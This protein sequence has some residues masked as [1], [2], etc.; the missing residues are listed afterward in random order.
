MAAVQASPLTYQN[1]AFVQAVCNAYDNPEEDINRGIEREDNTLVVRDDYPL[2]ILTA[3]Q[4]ANQAESQFA[5]PLKVAILRY[6][7]TYDWLHQTQH[8]RQIPLSGEII[9]S[10]EASAKERLGANYQSG[11]FARSAR[12]QLAKHIFQT[13]WNNSSDEQKVRIVRLADSPNLTDLIGQGENI[14]YDVAKQASAL[15]IVLLQN[16]LFRL[17]ASVY[18]AF[19]AVALYH[20]ASAIFSQSIVPI[21]AH[22]FLLYAPLPLVK[23]ASLVIDSVEFCIHHWIAIPLFGTMIVSSFRNTSLHPSLQKVYNIVTFPINIASKLYWIPSRILLT[24]LSGG[25]NSHNTIRDG[26]SFYERY[27]FQRGIQKAQQAWET[28]LH[29]EEPHQQIEA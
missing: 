19:K 6:L 25:L 1:L 8:L 26:M 7:D 14:L 24:C 15:A 17:I 28:L 4:R 27:L 9:A 21:L 12:V 5:D 13:A 10:T 2:S 29:I 11:I 23:I 3:G 16:Q 20:L 18:I 22:K